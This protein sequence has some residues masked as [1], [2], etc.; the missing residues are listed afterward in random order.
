[1]ALYGV[2]YAVL[3]S[4]LRVLLAYHII[5]QVGYMVAA[6]G[7]GSELA[8]DGAAAHAVNNLLYKGLLFMSVGAVAAT[9]GRGN[10]ADLGGLWRRQPA[11]LGLYLVGAASICG[12]PLTNGF[13]SK[14]MVLTA[15]R[16]RAALVDV[17]AARARV[18]GNLRQR[19]P[20]AAVLRVVRRQSDVDAKPAPWNMLAAMAVTAALCTLIG[21]VPDS[22]YRFLPVPTSYQAYTAA[23]V[24]EVIQLVVFASFAFFLLL[25]NLSVARKTLLD[26]DVSYRTA[27]PA[28]RA[29]LVGRTDA[30]FGAVQSIADR[31]AQ[32]VT[33]ALRDPT[34]WFAERRR[35]RG[36][37]DPDRSR[38]PLL[39]PLALTVATF[40]VIA[41][42][43]LSWQRPPDRPRVPVA[44]ATAPGSDS[45][46]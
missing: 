32:G 13:L 2:V 19:R 38:P 21:L 28:V 11:L 31:I 5:S 16:R 12:L 17:P 34:T 39:T 29:L 36:D 27:A 23:H 10:L 37:F 15:R 30:L 25:P 41:I 1:M 35:G 24:I 44:G 22:L 43:L 14:G 9:T 45:G 46:R 18:G 4:D 8:I 26:V 33:Q 6:A 3:A 20:E 42:V 7:I 40:V